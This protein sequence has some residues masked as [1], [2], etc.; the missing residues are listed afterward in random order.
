[1]DFEKL[2]NNVRKRNM[3]AYFAKNSEEAVKTA[4]TR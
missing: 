4:I 2:M 3:S 1:M